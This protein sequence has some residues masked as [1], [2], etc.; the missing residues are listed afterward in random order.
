M[1]ATFEGYKNYLLDDGET[2]S[3]AREIAAGDLI[4]T[5]GGYNPF[6]VS[7]D[8]LIDPEELIQMLNYFIKMIGWMRQP[9][10][11]L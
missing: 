6:N 9:K 11:A 3:D 5:L 8:Q 7:N 2:D 1:E 10:T 4:P